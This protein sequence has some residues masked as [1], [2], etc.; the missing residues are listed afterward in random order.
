MKVGNSV[1]TM[2]RLNAMPKTK[3]MFLNDGPVNSP[4]S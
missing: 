1:F 4:R 2:K 3:A